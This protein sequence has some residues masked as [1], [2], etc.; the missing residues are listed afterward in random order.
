MAFHQSSWK[1]TTAIFMDPSPSYWINIDSLYNVHAHCHVALL[2]DVLLF[3]HT[4]D[5]VILLY[6]STFLFWA[7][8]QGASHPK[9][10]KPSHLIIYG[11]SFHLYVCP[12]V[13]PYIH[14]YIHPLSHSRYSSL[15]ST[16]ILLSFL[17]GGF[18]M[19]ISIGVRR[20]VSKGVEDGHMPFQG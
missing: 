13:H 7:S 19:S 6:I 14:T 18:G 20:G 10:G 12:S 1:T 5:K 3:C 4:Y 11:H 9:G 15:F 2:Y 17:F 8:A 16:C